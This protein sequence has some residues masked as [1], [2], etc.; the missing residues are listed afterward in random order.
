MADSADIRTVLNDKYAKMTALYESGD[1]KPYSELF[2]EDCRLL[3]PG[4]EEQNG[5]KVIDNILQ[6]MKTSGVAKMAI[7]QEEAAGFG[8]LAYSCGTFSTFKDDGSLIKAEKFL[9]FLK[10]IDGNYYIHIDCGN[11]NGDGKKA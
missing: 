9:V 7:T 6:S 4:K 10:K 8:D 5:R 1:V 11:G 3:F 2:T